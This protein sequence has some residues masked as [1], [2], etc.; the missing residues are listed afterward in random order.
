MDTACFYGKNKYAN[1]IPVDGSL[2]DDDEFDSDSEVP[3]IPVP[4]RR[5]ETDDENS[6]V[7]NIPLGRLVKDKKVIKKPRKTPAAKKEWKSKHLDPYNSDNLTFTGDI[8]LPSCIMELNTPAEFFKFLFTNDLISM[9]VEQSNLKSVQDNLNKPV[10][11]GYDKLYKIRA[12][13]EHIR[14]RLLLVPKEEYLAVDEQMITI[15]GRHELKQYNPAKPDKSEYKNQVFSGALGFSYN[16]GLFAGEQ[17][18][19]IPEGAPDL[20]VY[21]A[22]NGL[23]PLGTVRMNRVPNAEMPTEKELKQQSRGFMV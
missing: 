19:K 23:L 10:Q 12:L 22:K 5:P 8:E 20:G 14:Q 13:L 17:S 3:L 21:L 11:P 2:S 4:V 7:E 18:N 16:F 9:I 1:P 15:K 6:D